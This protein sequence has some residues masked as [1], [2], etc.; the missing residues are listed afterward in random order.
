M[1]KS[2]TSNGSPSLVPAAS[3]VTRLNLAKDICFSISSSSTNDSSSLEVKDSSPFVV[4]VTTMAGEHYSRVKETVCDQGSAQFRGTATAAP[5]TNLLLNGDPPGNDLFREEP[6]LGAWRVLH[7]PGR[8][9]QACFVEPLDHPG[10]K[11]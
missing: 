4:P 10:G 5:F 9:G 3:F 11:G 1:E 7:L 2:T 6:V 8:I